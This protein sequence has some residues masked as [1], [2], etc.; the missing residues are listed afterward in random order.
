VRQTLEEL[1]T[2]AALEVSVLLVS[3]QVLDQRVL[4]DEA[5]VTLG[6]RAL[7]RPHTCRT[8]HVHGEMMLYSG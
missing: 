6:L 2:F 3:C 7:V 8:R 5:A 1:A 4:V